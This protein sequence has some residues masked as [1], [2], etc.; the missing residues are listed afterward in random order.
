MTKKLAFL[1]ILL[2]FF[3]LY[4]PA[5]KF[6]HQKFFSLSYKVKEKYVNITDY[7]EKLKQTHLNQEKEIKF[8]RKENS[9]LKEYKYRF[10]M[11]KNEFDSFLKE[12]NASFSVNPQLKMVRVISYVNF[13]DLTS[14]LLSDSFFSGDRIYGALKNGFAVG[15]VVKR[16]KKRILLLNT[17][18]ECSYAVEIGENKAQGIAI[19]R[20]DGYMEIRF[21]PTYKKVKVGDEVITSGLDGIFYYGIKVG[22]VIEVKTFGSYQIAL[23]KP[24]SKP[25]RPKYLWII[26]R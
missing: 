9:K 25:H 7:L 3:F 2:L 16:K 17:N 6:I 20:R 4:P 8:L 1:L 5:N 12:C 24:Y 23:I 19:G 14:L 22:K 15:I 26:L 11:L 18:P 13:G 10:F 21:I